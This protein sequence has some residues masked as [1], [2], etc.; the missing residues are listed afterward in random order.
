M[1]KMAET[2]LCPSQVL[3]GINPVT[4]PTSMVPTSRQGIDLGKE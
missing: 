4:T 3:G 2:A 1:I